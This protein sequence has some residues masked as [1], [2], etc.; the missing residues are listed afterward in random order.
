MQI[1][2]GQGCDRIRWT[3]RDFVPL[4]WIGVDDAGAPQLGAHESAHQ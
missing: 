4:V 2:V 3:A 1:H